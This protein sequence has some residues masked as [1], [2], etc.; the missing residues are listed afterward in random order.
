MNKILSFKKIVSL[1]IAVFALAV[2]FGVVKAETATYHALTVAKGGTGSGV[3]ETSKSSYNFNS[4]GT[5][6]YNCFKNGTV[7][8][9][10]AKANSG[11]SLASWTGCDSST[12][13]SCKVTMSQAKSVT[14]NFNTSDT[15]KILK[16]TKTA[17]GAVKSEDGK[18]NCGLTCDASYSV[19]VLNVG[20]TATPDSGYK[21]SGW[22]NAKDCL[23]TYEQTDGSN[24]CHVRLS[25]EKKGVTLRA[26]FKK[27]GASSSS[28]SLSAGT[29]KLKFNK[30]I[31]GTITSG[32]SVINCGAGGAACD[33]AYA[34]DTEV[35]LTATPDSGYMFDGFR[36]WKGVSCSNAV[37]EGLNNIA[38]YTC[39]FKINKNTNLDVRFVEYASITVNKSDSGTGSGVVNVSSN[40]INTTNCNFNSGVGT[41][42]FTYAPKGISVKL[43]AKPSA[44]SSFNGWSGDACAVSSQDKKVCTI[45]L[46]SA[47]TVSAIF[48]T[49]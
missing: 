9:L 6:C 40:R 48:K 26:N 23:D 19:E 2:F 10:V 22:T 34:K 3:V 35:T 31:G 1:G 46:N 49:Q 41:S 5:T 4:D 43:T 39:E 33:T 24:I 12:G 30:P 44:G 21:F 17:G 8:N 18:I 36:G 20:L 37:N 11:S 42:C 14:V 45:T 25:K 13:S 29:F 47:K 38:N 7:V 16:V 15:A 32:D 27:A 28:S